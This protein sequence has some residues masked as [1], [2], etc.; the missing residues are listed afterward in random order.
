AAG[1]D[2]L[3]GL[4]ERR[5]AGGA[6][7]GD[8]HRRTGETVSDGEL[9]GGGVR[10]RRGEQTGAR[11]GGP[12]GR[13]P[14]LVGRVGQEAPERRTEHDA[15]PRLGRRGG[16]P[17]RRQRPARGGEH[18]PGHTVGGTNPSARTWRQ[19]MASK[20]PA[21]PSV[22]PIAPLMELTGTLRGPKTRVIATASIAS[23]KGVPVPCAE[24]KPTRAG[25]TSA[26]ASAASIARAAPRP[27]RSGAVMCVASAAAPTPSTRPRTRARRRAACAAS[28]T[29]TTALPS[30]RTSPRR[31]ASK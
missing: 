26:S 29:T 13:E 20:A 24:T 5:E 19:R 9:A 12:L 16:E 17:R 25:A 4:A 6:T 3:D 8:R 2:E 1:A 31:V 21:A 15:G 22:W 7:G 28:S 11:A 27:S 14:A 18:A 23:L 30:P 10:H